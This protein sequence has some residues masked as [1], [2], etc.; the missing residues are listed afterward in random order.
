MKQ[1]T[2][3]QT[4]AIS[5]VQEKKSSIQIETVSPRLNLIVI[6]L[7]LNTIF[8]RRGVDVSRAAPL[9]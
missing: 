9:V 1:R 3:T 6:F 2:V 5:V 4:V 7:V 8:R